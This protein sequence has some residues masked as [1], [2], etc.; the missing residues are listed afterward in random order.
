MIFTIDQHK[1]RCL[2]IRL[3]VRTV[4]RSMGFLYCLFELLNYNNYLLAILLT[5]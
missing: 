3:L 5:S 2:I 4:Y 1:E